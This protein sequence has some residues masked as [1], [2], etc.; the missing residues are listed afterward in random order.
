MKSFCALF[1]IFFIKVCHL[2]QVSSQTNAIKIPI[3]RNPLTPEM[4]ND[5]AWELNVQRQQKTL[6]K[7]SKEPEIPLRNRLNLVYYGP[8]SI[9]TPPKKLNVLFDTGSPILWVMT[10]KCSTSACVNKKVNHTKYDHKKSKT[11]EK[12]EKSINLTYVIGWTYGKWAYETVTLGK[13]PV[14]KQIF[15]EATAISEADK[16][17]AYDGILG[18]GY[19]YTS[20]NMFV[21]KLCKQIK[22]D[23]KFSFYFTPNL[24]SPTAGELTLCG[25][26]KSKFKGKLHYVYE[27]K[28]GAW[29]IPLQKVTTPIGRKHITEVSP[30]SAALMDTGTSFILGPSR[31]INFIYVLLNS[32]PSK[33][34]SYM[35]EV[36]CKGVDDLPEISFNFDGE[37]FTLSGKDY[38]I[39]L[40]GICIVGFDF[41]GDQ[42]W[43]LGDIFFR[44]FY[45]EFDMA[46]HRIGLAES[47]HEE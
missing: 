1:L 20:P 40:A 14:A 26:D 11:Y 13:I 7:K 28:P 6:K 33:Q 15:V 21:P 35:R 18:L 22:D 30:K 43:T 29:R 46:Q 4:L 25:K 34:F 42:E 47:I 12:T 23:N 10:E 3:S 16:Q 45:A 19:N 39:K 8:I 44:K 17:I 31:A 36:D 41:S 9:G 37:E 2:E 32:K 27:T 5:F 38:I 24:T